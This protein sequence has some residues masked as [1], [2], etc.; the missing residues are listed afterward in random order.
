[1]HTTQSLSLPQTYS[2][3]GPFQAFLRAVSAELLKMKRSLALWLTFIAPLVITAL[4]LA[5]FYDGGERFLAGEPSA[6][7]FITRQTLIYWTLLMQP[8]FV[9]LETALVAQ[10]D[11][12]GD[13]WKQLFSLP[14]PRWSIYA[15]KLF[16]CAALIALS[17]VF[18]FL[19]TILSG[20]LFNILKPGL[21]FAQHLPLRGMLW[22]FLLTFL[23][24]LLTIAIHVWVA[25]Y[26]RSFVVASGFGIAMTTA[27]V[28]VINSKVAGYYPWTMAAVILN[29]LQ[30]GLP[31]LDLLGYSL[32]AALV[33]SL[34][35][36]LLFTHRDVF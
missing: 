17:I 7:I 14:L 16:V 21:G 22:L 31:Y 11:H 32:L 12:S 3:A 4:Q 33:V 20:V 5:V 35:G 19:D 15:A 23:S 26:W 2:P 1:M 18:L 24:S 27:G 8:L 29:K 36:S 25:M 6:W 13:H 9:T 30:D 10:L 34:V 28:L